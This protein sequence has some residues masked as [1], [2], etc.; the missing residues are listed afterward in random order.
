[1]R[2][3]GA[4]SEQ[5]DGEAEHGGPLCAATLLNLRPFHIQSCLAAA[6]PHLNTLHH[7]PKALAEGRAAHLIATDTDEPST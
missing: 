2:V 4:G 1:M 3:T 5:D 6:A 7:R